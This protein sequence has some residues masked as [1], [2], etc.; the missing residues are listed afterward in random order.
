MQITKIQMISRMLEKLI[1]NDFS[2]KNYYHLR[3][4]SILLYH[5]INR[6]SFHRRTVYL[7]D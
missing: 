4:P 7:F 5:S 6:V 2:I 1:H 3:A